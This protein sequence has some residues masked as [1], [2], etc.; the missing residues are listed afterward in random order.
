MIKNKYFYIL[1]CI[2]ISSITH[3]SIVEIQQTPRLKSTGGVGVGAV[4][5]DEAT[6]L[7]PAPMAFFQIGALYYQKNN[8][9]T[10]SSTEATN[11]LFIAS[12]SKG[13]VG[14]SVSY[15]K[16]NDYKLINIS[17]AAPVS[18]KSAM[19]VTYRN[20]RSERGIK[21]NTFDIGV[22]HAITEFFT[23]GAVIKN[24]QRKSDL[25]TRFIIG[26]Q[27][28]YQDFISILLDLGSDWE[29]TLKEDIIYG[30]GLQFKTFND[31]YLRLGASKDRKLNR[32][33]SGVG[34]SWVSPKILL[35]VAVSN[36]EEESSEETIKDTSFSIS[37]KF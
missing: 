10:E 37:Y 32:S 36:I 27:F 33:Q 34:L 6:L 22:S 11:T 24:P 13:R 14:G 20:Y 4:L 3:S 1:F 25:D 9:S 28:V 19:G 2:L 30:A 8:R 12:D 26:G 23:L 35:N 16:N 7:N 5:L 29:N 31:I 18:E 17:L 21:L 15:D